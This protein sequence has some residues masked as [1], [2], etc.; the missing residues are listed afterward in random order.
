M[1]NRSLSHPQVKTGTFIWNLC[2]WHECQSQ[3]FMKTPKS[4]TL[5][6]LPGPK[7]SRSLTLDD[8]QVAFMARGPGI[9][10]SGIPIGGNQSLLHRCEG[11]WPDRTAHFMGRTSPPQYY[12]LW[13]VDD[14]SQFSSFACIIFGVRRNSIRLPVIA[15]A[16]NHL[17]HD[18]PRANW[19]QMSWKPQPHHCH[20][21]RHQ[22]F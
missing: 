7:V 2:Y 11:H 13:L 17:S 1:V 3:T 8:N 6:P 21:K 10:P 20:A 18:G 15:E 22:V 14:H 19:G 16:V 5:T 9:T 4:R 12:A